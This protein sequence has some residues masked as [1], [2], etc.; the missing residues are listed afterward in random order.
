MKGKWKVRGM[1]W[2]YGC[3]AGNA[4]LGQ[5]CPSCGYRETRHKSRRNVRRSRKG[6]LRKVKKDLIY[7]NMVDNGQ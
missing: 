1:G 3:D 2:C 7:Q 6:L 5:K 4:V